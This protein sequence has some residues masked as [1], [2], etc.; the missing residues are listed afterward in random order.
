MI[1]KNFEHFPLDSL[2]FDLLSETV[3]SK[4]YYLTPEG[5]KYKS[6]TTVLGELNKQAIL[7]WRKR[8]GEE[9]ANKISRT[10]STKGTGYHNL[11]EKYL[12]NQLTD[13]EISG[14]MPEIKQMFLRMKPFLDENVTKI[15]GIEKALYSDELRLAGR[16]DLIAEYDGELSIVDHKT[17]GKRKEESWITNYFYQA[18]IYAK[19]LQE[20]T[21]LFP[22]QIVIAIAVSDNQPQIFIKE[23]EEYLEKAI[24][25]VNQYN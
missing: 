4:R 17:S 8:V 3:N 7:E 14:I 24:E 20:R 11:I 21:G 16:V 9:E 22:K 19:M 6:V 1:L 5:N 12:K 25:F 15:Y 18:S 13:M 23:T 2:N 10:A